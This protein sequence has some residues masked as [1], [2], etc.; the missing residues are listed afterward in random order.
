LVALVALSLLSGCAAPVED[1]YYLT[2]EQDQAVRDA[3]EP[4]GCVMVPAPLLLNIIRQLP[5]RVDA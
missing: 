3:C 5:K 4:A 1:R 2:V